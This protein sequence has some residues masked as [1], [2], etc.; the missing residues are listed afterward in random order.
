MPRPHL[1][2]TSH[3]LAD[4]TARHCPHGFSCPLCGPNK[5]VL[6]AQV[7]AVCC[8]P[9]SK[10]LFPSHQE[11]ALDLALE[12]GVDSPIGKVVVSA[13]YEGGAAEQH[14]EWGPAVLRF[15]G[16]VMVIPAPPGKQTA[17]CWERA[18]SS[19]ECCPRWIC[20]PVPHVP[21]RH[22]MVSGSTGT[23]LLR[24]HS[25]HQGLPV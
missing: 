13:V 8:L 2:P 12:G 18:D 4:G 11:G 23:E 16:G 3:F 6:G 5:R 21:R 9:G 17:A 24:H 25:A 22:M 1:V 7:P 20:P 10:G 15:G 19:Q 14:G